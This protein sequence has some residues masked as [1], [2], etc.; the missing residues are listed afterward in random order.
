MLSLKIKDE[1]NLK[2]Q[3]TVPTASHWW[4]MC[5]E[6]RR[7]YHWC[8]AGNQPLAISPDFGLRLSKT[9]ELALHSA[10]TE[11]TRNGRLYHLSRTSYRYDEEPLYNIHQRKGSPR[12][13][14]ENNHYP[15]IPKKEKVMLCCIH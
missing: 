6:A 8:P 9:S 5:R 7:I 10:Y 15:Y 11:V 1:R 13:T 2:R 3:T 12:I 4:R 14:N